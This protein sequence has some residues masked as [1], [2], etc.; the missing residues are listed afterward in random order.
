M[1][2]LFQFSYAQSI[3]KV[4]SSRALFQPVNYNTSESSAPK[5]AFLFLDTQLP[6]QEKDSLR[7]KNNFLHALKDNGIDFGVAESL[8]GYYNFM[9]GKRTGSAVAST[10]D[11]NI[12]LDLNQLIHLPGGKLYADFEAH[13]FQNPT[14]LLVGDLQVFDKNTANPFSQIFELWYEQKFFRNTLRLKVGKIDANAEFSLIDNGLDFITSSAHVTP[15]LFVFPT[16]PDPMPGINLFFTPGKL[17]YTSFAIFDANQSNHFLDFSGKPGSVQPTLNGKLWVG[18][19]GLTWNHLSG[20]GDDG[21]LRLGIWK[22]TG[23][24]TRT[25]DSSPIQGADGLY[26]VFN[27]T[28]WKPGSDKDA[29]R[30]LRMF[31]E[32][33]HSNE[34][35]AP[36]YQHFGGGLL[37]TGIKANRPDDEIGASSQYGQI[38][39]QPGL[40]WNYELAIESFY[41]ISLASWINVQPDIQYIVHPGGEYANALIGTLQLNVTF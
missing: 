7:N 41:K 8:E 6:K 18:E 33:A 25:D 3:N 15:T 36:I 1:I 9:G 26:I 22:H 40:L 29:N 27:Q 13:S 32:Y 21:N 39:P 14:D 24:F 19:T 5:H 2:F 12:S 4:N 17:F 23:Q 38:S 28:I 30:G 16:F 34:G 31:L 37:W 10:F 11:A 20:H 35:V